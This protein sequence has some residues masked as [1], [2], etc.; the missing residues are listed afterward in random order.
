MVCLIVQKESPSYQTASMIYY[1]LHHASSVSASDYVK[2]QHSL[3]SA[4]GTKREHTWQCYVCSTTLGG[5]MCVVQ[6]LMVLLCELPLCVW[7]GRW[8]EEEVTEA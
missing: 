5:A 3:C 1:M 4:D 6:W 2:C 8:R 7:Y